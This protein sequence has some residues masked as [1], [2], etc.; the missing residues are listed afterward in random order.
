MKKLLSIVLS[1]VLAAGLLAGCSSSSSG[2]TSTA[3]QGSTPASTAS[4]D[5]GEKK[6]IRVA[7]WGGQARAD[8]TTQVCEMYMAEHPDVQIE[9]EF[10]D[11]TGYFDKLAVEAASGTMPDIFQA[12]RDNVVEFSDKD[13][14]LPLNEYAD[15]G[16]LDFSQ[17]SEDA[18]S[19]LTRDGNLYGII[20]GS[21]AGAMSYDPDVVKEA[22]VEIYDAMP[23]SEFVQA[24]KTIYEK[25]G[26]QT[27]FDSGDPITQVA[28]IARA[29][30][31][32]LYS[33]DGK[34]L[35]F[36]DA[37]IPTEYFQRYE[38]GLKEGYIVDP[39]I[40]VER[41]VGAVEQRPIVDG[42]VWNDFGWCNAQGLYDAMQGA[43]RNMAMVSYPVA[44]DATTPSNY[45][46][47]GTSFHVSAN[48]QYPEVCA[49]FLRQ[50][51]TEK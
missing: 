35:G 10:S 15:S 3:S 32:Q 9:V 21:I 29:K 5:N 39:Q 37:S 51:R 23:W 36:P 38:D 30:G 34:S 14:L 33:E 19:T 31:Y 24:A 44:D 25:T 26:V 43:G 7:W 47:V 11:Y 28:M 49:D 46:R 1:V 8:M 4:T 45:L 40:Y 50:Y 16:V 41:D 13:L 6:V 27:S 18:K 2:S 42:M 48:T 12:T 20:L 17:V 22:G